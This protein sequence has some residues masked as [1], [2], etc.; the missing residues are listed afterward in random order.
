MSDDEK[1]NFNK[2]ILPIIKRVLP[3]VLAHDI[4]YGVSEE[5]AIR[6]EILAIEY[7]KIIKGKNKSSKIKHRV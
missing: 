5:T 2:V 1:P 4:I 7:E 3:D 6:R